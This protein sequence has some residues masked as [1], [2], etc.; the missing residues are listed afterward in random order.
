MGLGWGRTGVGE[1]ARCLPG[2]Q[3]SLLP[4]GAGPGLAE[5]SSKETGPVSEAPPEDSLGRKWPE[6]RVEDRDQAS[7]CRWAT[8][9]QTG[10]SRA[11]TFSWGV[12]GDVE[13][14]FCTFR[15]SS[16]IFLAW[17]FLHVSEVSL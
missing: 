15:G 4:L 13:F 8:R 3:Y 11:R 12:G 17:W 2:E 10:S 14:G 7:W 5:V 9:A 16:V 1:P 6:G